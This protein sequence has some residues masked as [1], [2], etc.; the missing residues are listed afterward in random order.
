MTIEIQEIEIPRY[1]TFDSNQYP[2]SGLYRVVWTSVESSDASLG[3]LVWVNHAAN[4]TTSEKVRFVSDL[5]IADYVLKKNGFKN[6]L[7]KRVGKF[8]TDL[9]MKTFLLYLTKVIKLR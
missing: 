3:S 5:T 4:N 9:P 1:L 6:T 7:R 8:I 2:N